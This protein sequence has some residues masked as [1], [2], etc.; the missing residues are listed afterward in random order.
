M[1]APTSNDLRWRIV[2][3]VL[4]TRKT[5][6]ETATLL[7][8]TQKTVNNILAR[9]RRY[10][11][12]QPS[13]FGRPNVMS[14]IN[15]D[16]AFMLMEYVMRHPGAYLREAVNYIEDMTGGQFNA[17]S[18]WRCLKRHN[19]TRKKVSNVFSYNYLYYCFF[20]LS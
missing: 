16:E 1:P 17:L 6:Y 10:G 13:R 18:L 12:V 8:V 9:F 3:L 7:G 2:W 11:N 19:F 15:R 14:A 5:T 4:G 20:F